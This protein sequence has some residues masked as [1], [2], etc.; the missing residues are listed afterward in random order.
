M[1]NGAVA[2]Q[3]T[4]VASVA[5]YVAQDRTGGA[6]S[7]VLVVEDD[8]TIRSI[9]AEALQDEGFDVVTA[10]DGA[11]ALAVIDRL[12]ADQ[13]RAIVLDMW[14]PVM[15]GRAFVESYRRSPLPHAPIIAL[16]AM[17]GDRERA[18]RVDVAC[19]LDKPFEL[20]DVLDAVQALAA[21]N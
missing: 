3:E 13:P 15:E 6:L 5:Q 17:R 21:S 2:R 18:Q 20:A 7:R 1:G 14:M 19:V 11:A 8:E 4:N 16:A 9:L 12:G 10:P